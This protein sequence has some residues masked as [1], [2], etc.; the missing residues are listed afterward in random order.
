MKRL[1]S[2]LLC[3][4]VIACA[5]LVVSAGVSKNETVY[6]LLKND[7]AVKETR[8]VN[9]LSGSPDGDSWVDYGAYSTVVNDV[10]DVKPRVTDTTVVWPKSAFGPGGLFYQGTALPYLPFDIAIEYTL[11]GSLIKPADLPGKSGRVGVKISISNNLKQEVS[12]AWADFD[13][14]KHVDEESVYTP[15]MF[16][17]TTNVPV[18]EWTDINAPGATEVLVGDKLQLGWAV[19]P[20]PDAQIT[21]EMKGSDVEL[22]PLDMTVVPMALPDLGL[23]K[24]DDQLRAYVD[25]LYQIESAIQSLKTSSGALAFGE[26]QVSGGVQQLVQGLGLA[27]PGVSQVAKGS[28]DLSAGLGQVLQLHQQLASAAAQLAQ[29]PDPKIQAL[30][31]QLQTEQQAISQLNQAALALSQGAAAA[32]AGLTQLQT[33]VQPLAGGAKASASGQTQLTGGVGELLN[34]VHLARQQAVV[35]Y[36]ELKRGEALTEIARTQSAN[37]RS[38]MD[39]EHNRDSQVQFLLR[40]EGVNENVTPEAPVEPA[41]PLSLWQRLVQFVKGLFGKR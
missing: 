24:T 27:V 22:A 26:L 31:A 12:L 33:Q 13:G 9:W 41:K 18:T 17:V 14:I 29:Y 20:Y 34:A 1:V 23:A 7:G 39:N 19:F 2:L 38:F 35:Q 3:L 25:G 6:V 30:A 8:V 32:N 4:L 37:Y 11:N 16:Q 21:F 28:A 5:P 36:N 10:S 15:F 40:T